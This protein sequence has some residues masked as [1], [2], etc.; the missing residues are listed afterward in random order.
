DLVTWSAASCQLPGRPN[1]FAVGAYRSLEL[2]NA[3]SSM[4]R[5]ALDIRPGSKWIETKVERRETGFRLRAW[6]RLPKARPTVKVT[7]K[8]AGLKFDTGG[9]Q[10]QLGGPAFPL[11][12]GA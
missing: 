7:A 9:L 3:G 1:S 11:P 2:S 10:I 6:N 4:L 8:E 12:A 5:W